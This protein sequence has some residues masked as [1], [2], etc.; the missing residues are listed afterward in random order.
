VAG[1]SSDLDR[2][3]DLDAAEEFEQFVDPVRA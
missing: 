1:G 3:F 2:S